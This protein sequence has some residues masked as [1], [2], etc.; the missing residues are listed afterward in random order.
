M[1]AVSLAC[2]ARWERGTLLMAMPDVHGVVQAGRSRYLMRN[3][4]GLPRSKQ[5]RRNRIQFRLLV[6]L[7]HCIVVG[8]VSMSSYF[9]NLS[10]PNVTKEA[11]KM[12][13]NLVLQRHARMYNPAR[14]MQGLCTHA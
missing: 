10:K 4:T 3:P 12:L 2:A 1:L 5:Q 13:Q 14:A 6:R 11:E 9:P 7:R 8:D